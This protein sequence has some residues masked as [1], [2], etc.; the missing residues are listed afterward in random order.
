MSSARRQSAR[1]SPWRWSGRLGR[2]RGRGGS[3]KNLTTKPQ[4]HQEHK[5][6]HGRRS[7]CLC[8]LV[9]RFFGLLSAAPREKQAGPGLVDGANLI[10]DEARAEAERA[11]YGLGQIGRNARSFLGPDEPQPALLR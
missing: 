7:W 2:C 9:L 1:A 10:V 6:D 4:R 11:D 5:E 8:V 3:P